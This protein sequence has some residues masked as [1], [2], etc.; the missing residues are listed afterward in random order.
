MALGP[1]VA[2]RGHHA[3]RRRR[4][5]EARSS[6]EWPFGANI[7]FRAEVLERR[8][9]PGE[10]GRNG[11]TLLSGEEFALVERRSATRDGRSGSSRERSST[12]PCIAERC[13][14]SYYWRRLW[15]AGVTRARAAGLPRVSGLRLVAA[16]PMRLGLYV[17]TRDRVYLYR[18][19]E[20][21]GFLVERAR[22]RRS[23]A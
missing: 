6:A 11:T 23:A 2:V 17:F 19:A 12:T 13:R 8:A 20:T 9:V 1:A 21:A 16:A 7:A 4:R 10:L 5:A 18:S 15:W 22:L 14:S 3:I